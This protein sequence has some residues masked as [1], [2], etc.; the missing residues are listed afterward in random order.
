MPTTDTSEQ[1]LESLMIRYMTGTDGLF[2]DS[3]A[4][5]VICTEVLEHGDEFWQRFWCK[6]DSA[7]KAGRKSG[8]GSE[9]LV[10]GCSMRL[11]QFDQPGSL[12]ESVGSIVP[13]LFDDQNRYRL[14]AREGL[15]GVG[16]LPR[17]IGRRLHQR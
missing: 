15:A 6:L 2:A 7:E 17:A 14:F 9:G 3:S 5:V 13:A 10:V 11:P 16:G 1:G 12:F 4:D 8:S